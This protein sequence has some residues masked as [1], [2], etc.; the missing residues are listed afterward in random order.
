MGM[1]YKYQLLLLTLF[2]FN[3]L[4]GVFFAPFWV[5]QFNGYYFRKHIDNDDILN[6]KELAVDKF[7]N[8]ILVPDMNKTNEDLESVKEVLV[9]DD[10]IIEDESDES[11]SGFWKSI[12]TLGKSSVL[13]KKVQRLRALRYCCQVLIDD[14]E[15][16]EVD[17]N[18]LFFYL[19]Y[20]RIAAYRNLYLA[21]E[22]ISLVKDNVSS[23]QQKLIIDEFP[24]LIKPQNV[25]STEVFFDA[26]Q[27]SFDS[28]RFFDSLG[29]SF[30]MS[31]DVLCEKL[32]K[33]KDISKEDFLVAGIEVAI[34][35]II[36]GIE[37]LFDQYSRTI[38]SI[39]EVEQSI[40]EAVSYLDKA[41]PSIINYQAELARQSEIMIALHKC[42][43]AFVMAYEPL[44]QKVWG[45][46]TF[47]QFVHGINKDQL[48]LKSDDFRGD[49]QHLILVCTEYNKVYNAKTGNDTDK[50]KKP[51]RQNRKVSRKT[52]VSNSNIGDS[53]NSQLKLSRETI[54]STIRDVLN[55]K[56]INEGNTI[57]YLDLSNKKYAV[58]KLCEQFGYLSNKKI[59]KN[60]IIKCKNIK[61]V[62]DLVI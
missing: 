5:Y 52:N 43:K 31:C 61:E 51:S 37:G 57:A 40:H 7:Y 60:D 24:D 11:I 56:H 45:R 9:Y 42:N 16:F 17:N 47:R 53:S 38:A 32:E 2:V 4:V 23:R 30:Q 54:L 12:S 19:K 10:F 13:K 3:I 26:T 41:Y 33:E 21:K 20:Y 46:P 50:V 18:K 39:R 44:R 49:L 36:A 58:Q 14:I 35:G 6:G 22:L 55:N 48:Y 29:Q 28:D 25:N 62:I 34:D 1:F 8:S 59:T 27:V 15:K